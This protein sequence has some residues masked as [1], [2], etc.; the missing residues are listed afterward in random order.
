M[1]ADLR[2]ESLTVFAQYFDDDGP[3]AEPCIILAV[4][5]RM[6]EKSAQYCVQ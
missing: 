1:V 3:I 6:E 4:I 2:L 5:C